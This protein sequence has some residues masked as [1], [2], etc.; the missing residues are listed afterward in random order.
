M[1][2]EFSWHVNTWE[3][4]DLHRTWV[5]LEYGLSIQVGPG[6]IKFGLK[7]PKKLALLCLQCLSAHLVIQ[8][9]ITR[10]LNF[11]ITG[12]NQY[13]DLPGGTCFWQ[14]VNQ[15]LARDLH[16]NVRGA[17]RHQNHETKKSNW[18]V[19]FTS[20]R[21]DRIETKCCEHTRDMSLVHCDQCRKEAPAE[22]DDSKEVGK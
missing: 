20:W 9:K 18:R 5:I 2:F 21:Y 10:C 13:L 3:R 19:W 11:D 8:K 15:F 4:N 22:E 12:R 6:L 1:N 7:V 14:G 16:T 17:D